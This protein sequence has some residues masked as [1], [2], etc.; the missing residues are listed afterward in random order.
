MHIWH[1]LRKRSNSARCGMAKYITIQG[2]VDGLGLDSELSEA[3]IFHEI[4]QIAIEILGDARSFPER[5]HRLSI[6]LEWENRA[7]KFGTVVRNAIAAVRECSVVG[8]AGFGVGID[9]LLL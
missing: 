3:E 5:Q 2:Y 6:L 1:D 9:A 8:V 7:A 4:K